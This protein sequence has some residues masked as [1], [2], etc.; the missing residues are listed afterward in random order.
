MII[1]YARTSTL[2]Q[3]A[4]FEAQI[5]EL[6]AAGCEKVYQEQVSSVA[7]RAEL[8]AALD[9]VR[10]GDT[11]MV[12]KLDRLA[13]SIG[14]LCEI[15]AMLKRKGVELCIRDL[16]LDTSRP[17]GE[18]MVGMLGCIAQFERSIMLERQKVGIEAARVAGRYK[19]RAPTARAKSAEI[20]ALKAAGK[21]CAEIARELRIGRA[22]VYR[23]LGP[24]RRRRGVDDV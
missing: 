11:F 5:R 24:Y 23:V 21:G 18:L 10:E 9:Y 20:V 14:H 19:G 8:D 1:G 4:G 12:T 16:G 15:V 6:K 17:T 7:T 22:S 13:R 3:T 2:E